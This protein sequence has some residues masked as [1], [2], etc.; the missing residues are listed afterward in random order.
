LLSAGG[1]GASLTAGSAPGPEPSPAAASPACIAVAVHAL[2]RDGRRGA[3]RRSRREHDASAPEPDTAPLLGPQ[4]TEG[5]RTRW[6]EIRQGFVDDPQQSVLAADGLV[7]EVMQL[8]ATTFADHKQGIESQWHRGEEVSIEDLP[9]AL[10]QY[11]SFFER[12]L[13]TRPPAR[14]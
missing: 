11:R 8:L 14:P 6:Q 9:L 2:R 10:R 5:L 3:G 4:E 1:R 7:A 12:L 13:S